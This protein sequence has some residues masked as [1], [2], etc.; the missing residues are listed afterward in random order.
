[1]DRPAVEHLVTARPQL[2]GALHAAWG[3]ARA[4]E[5]DRRASQDAALRRIV[6]HAYEH[7]RYYRRLFDRHRL[8]PGHLRGVIDLDLVPL[9]GRDDLL[10]QRESDLLARGVQL[11]DLLTVPL[12]EDSDTPRLR[13]TRFEAFLQLIHRMRALGGLGLQGRDRVAVLSGPGGPERHGFA[14]H[15]LG[16]HR[17]RLFD[18][19][20]D[21]RATALAIAGFHPDVLIGPAPALDRLA[22]E[23]TEPVRPRLVVVEGR[24][25]MPRLRARLAGAFRSAVRAAYGIGGGTVLAA[26]CEE[27][28]AYHVV[29]GWALL[30][31]LADGRAALPGERGEVAVTLLHSFAMPILRLRLGH[32]ATRGGLCACGAPFATILAPDA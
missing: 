7:V 17:R 22:A 31:V 8:L 5:A 27:T 4:S 14:H 32:L 24:P 19:A 15:L 26:E 29:E 6:A 20:A 11:A 25:P 30:E 23:V 2:A 12:G 28:G 18:A 13:R 3:L 10:A 16:L 1:V 21:P 9:S